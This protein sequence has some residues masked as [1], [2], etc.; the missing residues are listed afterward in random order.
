MD[1]CIIY[2]STINGARVENG[3]VGVFNAGGMKVRMRIGTSMQSHAIDRVSLLAAS[4]DS[5]AIPD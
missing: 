5:H 4:L 3:E 2:K 1:E